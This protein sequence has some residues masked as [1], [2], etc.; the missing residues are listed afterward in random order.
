MIS[1][2][3]LKTQIILAFLLLGFTLVI[4][5][6]LLSANYFMRGMDNITLAHM[7]RAASSYQEQVPAQQRSATQRYGGYFISER[8]ETLPGDIREVFAEPPQQEMQLYK[9]FVQDEPGQPDHLYL[10]LRYTSEDHTLFV[11]DMMNPVSAP[12]APA[13]DGFRSLQ[14]LMGLALFIVIALLVL[15]WWLVRHVSRPVT[16]LGDWARQLDAERLKTPPP[17]FG[18]PELNELASLIHNSLNETQQTLDREQRFLSHASHELRTPISVIRNN[19]QLLRKMQQTTDWTP[20]HQQAFA[21][22]ERAG[23]TMKHLT[24]TLLWLSRDSQDNLTNNRFQLDELI[25]ELVDEHRSLLH[26]NQVSLHINTTPYPVELPEAPVRMVLSNL[27]RNAFI[28]CWEGDISIYQNGT[29]IVIENSDSGRLGDAYPTAQAA[30]DIQQ[31][32]FGLG[33]QLIRSLTTR[34]GWQYSSERVAGRYR[35]RVYFH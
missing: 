13:D 15:L 12:Q 28:H 5:Y 29:E 3:R 7:A 25:Q 2:L 6:S 11:A 23:A 4:G 22:L 16:A 30:N 19:L 24:E 26:E 17:N 34:L 31:T 9:Q 10:A 1:P 27:I 20:R 18:F 35:A 8:W 33:L 32:G 14:I 21:R